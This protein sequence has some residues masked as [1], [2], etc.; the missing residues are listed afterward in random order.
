MALTKN[1]Y[2]QIAICSILTI[3]SVFLFAW[4]Y[5]EY[6]A[7]QSYTIGSITEGAYKKLE[8]KDYISDEDVIFSQNINDVSFAVTNGR[9]L[10]EYTFDPKEF[11]GLTKDYAIFVNNDYLK[12]NESAGRITATYAIE[13]RNVDNEVIATTNINIDFTFQSNSSNLRVY[14]NEQHDDLGLLMN[15]FDKNDFIITL[16]ESPFVMDQVQT[17]DEYGRIDCRVIVADDTSVYAEYDDSLSLI[18][19]SSILVARSGSLTLF[20]VISADIDTITVDTDGEY[21]LEYDASSYE[22]TLTWS[23]ANFITVSINAKGEKL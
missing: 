8:I 11:N 9:A 3:I 12:C 21:E 15:Y 16:T 5:R 13:Y 19:N 1:H 4:Y 23:D 6:I 17:D 18:S 20:T 14:F 7:P 2:I 22:Y 10:Y